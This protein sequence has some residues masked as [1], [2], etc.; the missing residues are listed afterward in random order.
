MTD[1]YAVVGNPVSHSLSPS[2]H[3]RFAAATQ[4]DLTYEKLEAPLDGFAATAESFFAAGGKGLNVTLPFKIDAWRWVDGHDDA[5]R[6]SGAVN[7]IL[8]RGTATRGSSTDGLGLVADLADN[9]GWRLAGV[10]TLMLGAG[11]AAQSVASS[12]MEAGVAE[13]TIANRT[14]RKAERLAERFGV[15][16]CGLDELG[17]GWDVVVNASSAS[18]GGGRPSIAPQVVAG[19]RCYD[20]FYV[21]DGDTAFCRWAVEHGALAASDGL[22]M[23][24]EQAAESFALWRGVRPPTAGVVDALRRSAVS[25]TG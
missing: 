11:G 13:L 18:M 16:A 14:R 17:A 23:L 4:Q 9:L 15:V 1:R 8:L 24:V 2:I 25:K 5:A 6:L 10:R 12:L 3:A 20:M 22:G 21:P 7:T 19:S